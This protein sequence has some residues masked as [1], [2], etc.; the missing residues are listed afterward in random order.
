MSVTVCLFVAL[1]TV[2]LA[3]QPASSGQIVTGVAVDATGAVLPNAEVVLVGGADVSISTRT[4]AAGKFRFD[5]VPR[6]RYDVRISFEGFQTTT[7]RVTVGARAPAP[8]RVTLPLA[9][10]T[11][12]VT[13]TD[14]AAEVST[15][16]A[17]NSDAVSVDQTMLESLPVF[18]QDLIAIVSRFLDAGSL[19][20]GGVTV[21]VN[22]MEVSA[23]RVSA[24]AVQQIKINQDP[25]SAEY[26]RPGRGRIEILTKPGSAEYRG[27][28]N[29]IGRDAAFDATNAFAVTKPADRKRILEGVFGGPLGRGGRSSFLL[30]GHD[31]LE[32]QQ[33]FVFAIGPAGEL[34]DVAPQPSRR[35]LLSGSIVH[36][37]SDST[38]ISI[39]PSFE[40]ESDRNR[41]VGGTT[42]PS[43]G[44]NFEHREE[45]V[46]YTQQTLIRP[47]LLGQVQLLVGHEREPTVS[48]SAAPG[49][50]VA[51]AFTGGGG[52]GDLLRTETHMQM[53]SSVAWTKEHHL[54]QAGF[55]LPD[56]SRRG[57][58]D[59]TNFGGTFYFAGLAAYAAGQPYAFTQQQGQ[60]DLAFLEK[61]VGAYIKDDWQV[62]PGVTASIGLRYDWQNY[63]HDTNNFAPRVSLA[64]APGNAKT[65]VIR[66]GAGIFNDRSG[67]V[68]IADLLHYRPGGL[69]KYVV[70]DPSYPNPFQAGGASSI[71][72]S[73]VQLSPDVQIPQTLQYSA[74]ID[75]QLARTTVLSITY[76][77]S[78]GYHLFRSRDVNA[79]APPLYAVRP[80][81]A[82]TVIRQIES[83][84]RL[85]SD[86]LSITL[87][88]RMTKWFNGQAQYAISRARNDTN[89]ITWFPAN[90]YDLSGE[91]GRADFD[92]RHRLLLIGRVPAG[93]VVDLGVALTANSNA[94]YTEVLG[95]DIYNNGRGRARPAGVGRNTLTGAPFASLDLRAS[96]EFK[97]AG[98][99][100]ERTVGVGIDAFNLLDRVNYGT[101]VGT[102]G[103]PLFG[104]PV[105][106]RAPRQ[107]QFSVRLK[108]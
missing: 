82:Y 67:P 91:Y 53:M 46:T 93:H 6:G 11:Q 68:A 83:N 26:A 102:L 72:P 77:G 37:R 8:L 7:T 16:A 2:R 103:S 104:L 24:S 36:Q 87:R 92:R 52:Q 100:D 48:V 57:F 55:Q 47:T 70:T 66:A 69:V 96:R 88:G 75:H 3:G 105:S 13:V 28:F 42:L 34:H 81:P 101:Y 23:L 41:G 50:V 56:W 85:Q 73:I 30:S 51:G 62:K 89:G 15:A 39:R 98:G 27:E 9:K 1:A 18:D 40:Y 14:R 65:N 86:S 22:G 31:Q 10:V 107:L 43:A 25:Y 49:I 59:R 80:D 17:S 44:V 21:V 60:G 84:G 54:V 78:H 71:P 108:L 94:P 32:D 106:A 29:A 12:E 79:P 64:Y 19:G 90:D 20:N 76:T 45:Q 95:D 97:L 63:F 5:A 38:T 4:D 99:K 61:Q 58:Y 74:G 35:T 33:A